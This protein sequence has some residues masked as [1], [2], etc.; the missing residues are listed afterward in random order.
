MSAF[1]RRSLSNQ[2]LVASFPVL[3][4]GMLLIGSW[5]GR[6]IE[7]SAAYRIGGVT[8]MYVDSFIAPHVQSLTANEDLSAEDRA[9]L[10]QILTT[11][12]LSEKI[13]A[14]KIWRPDGRVLYSNTQ[15][16]IGR[17]FPIGEGLRVAL[18]G[19]VHSELSDLTQYENEFERDK[20]SRLIETYV[21]L[22]ANG[23][24][25]VVAAAEF[26]HSPER[27]TLES[28]AAQRQ[29]WL[30]VAAIVAGM[31]LLLFA[32]VR[33]GSKTIDAQ[34]DEL[35]NKVAQLTSLITQNEQLHDRVR[36]AAG[37][38]AALNEVFLRRI[39]ADLHDG[40]GQDLGLALMQF[41]SVGN[42]C[43]IC[44][45]KDDGRFSSSEEFKVIRM[46]MQSALTDLRAISAG[47]QL[48]EIDRLSPCE[49]TARAVRDYERKTG[50]SVTRESKSGTEPM[51]LSVKITLYRVLQEA[52]VNGFRHA[53][54]V[55]QHV[56]VRTEGQRL[57][58]QI[59]DCGQ[60]FD[61][62]KAASDGH[63]GLAG[64][65][66]RIEI[67]GGSFDLQS[68][69]GKGTHIRVTLPLVVPGMEEEYGSKS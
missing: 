11:P 69:P 16:L 48:P 3:L 31:Y 60:G 21:P 9:A 49:I 38:T 51:S 17:T 46:A 30:L 54:G 24:G 13:V 43:M 59:S 58:V 63:M 52:L 15:A 65:R 68:M 50:A 42:T 19:D 4:I 64:M 34:Q 57:L 33:R 41:E 37:R 36:R 25:T 14:L 29:S 39:S 5:M 40:P 47:L 23:A 44:P 22:H 8:G 66:E 2:F 45:G 35:N 20:W 28:R 62:S 10:N 18:S 56:D 12:P 26:Y 1:T 6:Q 7:E 32:L 67:L 53:G 55:G 61:P 27:W